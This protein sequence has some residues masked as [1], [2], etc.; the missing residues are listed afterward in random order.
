M[1]NKKKKKKPNPFAKGK[2]PMFAK[3]GPPKFSKKPPVESAKDKSSAGEKS[4]FDY[5]AERMKSR[6]PGSKVPP[7]ESKVPPQFAKKG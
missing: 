1:Q 3:G 4:K 5:L 2:A 6:G 7:S